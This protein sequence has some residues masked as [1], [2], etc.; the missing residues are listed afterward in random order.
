[1]DPSRYKI[2]TAMTETELAVLVHDHL[3]KLPTEMLVAIAKITL[4][5]NA[6]IVPMGEL[7]T[8]N[9]CVAVSG[10]EPVLVN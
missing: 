3:V 4:G 8:G 2:L 10:T 9:Y 5:P 6:C 7:G 1:E